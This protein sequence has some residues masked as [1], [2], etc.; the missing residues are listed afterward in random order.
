[1]KQVDEYGDRAL[2]ADPN[3]LSVLMTMSRTIA[4]NPPADPAARNTAMDKALG[5]VQRAQKVAKPDN[6]T[7][8]EWQGTQSRMH[9]VLGL[10]YFNKSQWPEAGTEFAE[11]LK[12]NPSDGLGQYRYGATVYTQLQTTLATLQQVNTEARQAQAAQADEIKM[13]YYAEKLVSLNTEFETRRDVTIDA[14][15]KALAIGGPFATQART[16]IE[17]LYKQKNKDSLEGLDPF[18]LAKKAELAALAP[19]APVAAPTARTGGR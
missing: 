9:G 17:P 1:M 2:T 12:A 18:I 3:N 4:E 19:V 15:A 5:Y 6:T 13:N 14:M 10:V 16:I 8:T 11:Y 7:D